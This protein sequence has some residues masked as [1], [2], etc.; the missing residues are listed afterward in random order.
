MKW[1]LVTQP[2]SMKRASEGTRHRRPS[3]Y[4]PNGCLSSRPRPQASEGRD[5]SGVV[6]SSQCC[7]YPAATLHRESSV[8]ARGEVV[9]LEPVKLQLLQFDGDTPSLSPQQIF[10]LRGREDEAR[11]QHRSILKPTAGSDDS[12]RLEFGDGGDG[13]LLSGMRPAF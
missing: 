2:E 4:G 10:H 11:V 1:A 5:R 9:N 6:E 7:A 3:L 12:L 13:D 8:L